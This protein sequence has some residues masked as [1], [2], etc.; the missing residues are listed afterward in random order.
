MLWLEGCRCVYQEH[1]PQKKH[2]MPPRLPSFRYKHPNN[3]PSPFQTRVR[4]AFRTSGTFWSAAYFTTSCDPA[5]G[6]T[7]EDEHLINHRLRCSSP[8]QWY[9]LKVT[10][11]F[12][13]LK[14][15]ALKICRTPVKLKP[16]P[17]FSGGP[18]SGAAVSRL[19][20]VHEAGHLGP[21]IFCTVKFITAPLDMDGL[22]KMFPLQAF[23]PITSL[24]IS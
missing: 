11:L 4:E 21:S 12:F 13:R 22:A 19:S 16:R 15:A 5:E 8:A 20:G 3:F 2:P 14:L 7:E 23:Y 9:S 6:N 18:S 10:L 17:R 1:I 24:F